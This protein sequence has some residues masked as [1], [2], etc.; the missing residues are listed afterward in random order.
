MAASVKDAAWL[1]W[2]ANMLGETPRLAVA[3]TFPPDRFYCLLDE[4]PVH[5]LPRGATNA[6]LHDD[7][8]QPLFLSP[9][10]RILPAGQLPDELIVQPELVSNFALQGTIAWVRDSAGVFPLPFWLGPKL[11]STICSLQPDQDA[12]ALLSPAECRTLAAARI[13]CRRDFPA[14]PWNSPGFV[15]KLCRNYRQKGYAVGTALLHPFQVAALRRYYRCL[16]RKGAIRFGDAQSPLR[17]KAHNE[18]VARFFHRYFT[19]I[20]S[21]VAGELV[22]PSYVYMAS[23][24]SG[25]ELKKHTD[26]EQCEFSVSFCLDFSPEPVDATPWPLCLETPAGEVKV[27]QALGDGLF[28]RGTR[29]PHY[30]GRL[31]EGLTSTSIFFH[32]VSTSFTGSLA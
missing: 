12:R 8:S 25:A 22:K 26:R 6:V 27:H 16:V 31:G 4:M 13:L 28:Y 19:N 5:L 9:E 32:Y 14:S 1:E 21:A 20:V 2:V 3:A 17:Y 18:P 23:Y 24:L 7:L 30:R 10:C 11:A 29:V 15:D